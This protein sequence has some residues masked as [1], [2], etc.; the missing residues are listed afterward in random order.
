MLQACVLQ[1]SQATRRTE[2]RVLVRLLRRLARAEYHT[3][4]VCLSMQPGLL[5]LC[6]TQAMSVEAWKGALLLNL[7]Y[8]ASKFIV[9]PA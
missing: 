5:V 9:I 2:D 3:D 8:G 4:S 1:K 6:S 7:L